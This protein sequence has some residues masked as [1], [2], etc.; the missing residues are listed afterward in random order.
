MDLSSVLVI[1]TYSTLQNLHG[2]TLF[3]EHLTGSS[4]HHTQSLFLPVLISCSFQPYSFVISYCLNYICESPEHR[5]PPVFAASLA[6]MNKALY[7]EY[8]QRE[9][10]CPDYQLWPILFL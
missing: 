9:L 5:S 2:V 8:G 10:A 3:I 6:L 1:S 4:I 7:S